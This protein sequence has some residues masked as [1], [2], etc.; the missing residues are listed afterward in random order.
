MLLSKTVFTLSTILLVLSGFGCEKSNPISANDA[1]KTQPTPTTTAALPKD[2]NYNAR[3]KVTKINNELG[4][5]ELDHE[6]IPGVMAAMRMEF[7][8]KNKA[9]LKPLK[10]G[11]QVDFVLEYNHPTETIVSIKKAK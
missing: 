7:F 2:G 5:V 3:G 1:V 8:V 9:E 4:S 6:D 10:I 11:D